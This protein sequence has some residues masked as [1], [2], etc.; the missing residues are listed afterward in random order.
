MGYATLRRSAWDLGSIGDDWRQHA[1]CTFESHTD[2]PRSTVG[3][4]SPLH[5]AA[6]AVHVCGHCPVRR[7]CGDWTDQLVAAKHHP[8][9][10]VQAGLVWADSTDRRGP[11]KVQPPDPGCGPW[12][13]ALRE[14]EA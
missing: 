9:G 10:M 5:P 4:G 3:Y 7:Q 13:K 1:V 2:Y 6:R 8:N 12:C 11:V 14:V